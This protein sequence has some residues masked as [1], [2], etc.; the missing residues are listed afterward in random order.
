MA[1]GE[2]A[3]LA[4]T[5]EYSQ[6]RCH[7]SS[8][9]PVPSGFLQV[10]TLRRTQRRTSFSCSGRFKS[11]YLRWQSTT[12]HDQGGSH[13]CM[14]VALTGL[15][16]HA[17]QHPSLHKLPVVSEGSKL[18]GGGSVQRQAGSKLR[19]DSI[20][21]RGFSQ[22]GSHHQAVTECRNH[23]YSNETFACNTLLDRLLPK[24]MTQQ[25]R[26]DT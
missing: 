8:K 17:C 7:T 19:Y 12:S 11:R 23:F 1:M 6:H 20:P 22:S 18:M 21:D 26:H 15:L 16:P 25:L 5:E 4:W 10:C 9:R 13:A 2:L 14:E 24:C 3:L